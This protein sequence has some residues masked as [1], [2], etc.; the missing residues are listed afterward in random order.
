MIIWSSSC[1]HLD[2]HQLVLTLVLVMAHRKPLIFLK[3]TRQMSTGLAINVTAAP[4]RKH[5]AEA[6]YV[7]LLLTN[8]QVQGLMYLFIPIVLLAWRVS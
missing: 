3:I 7:E 6:S 8:H 1:L 5:M 2:M 4:S